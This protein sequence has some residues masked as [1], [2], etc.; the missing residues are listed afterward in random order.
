MRL[1]AFQ[2]VS[3]LK[4]FME[5]GP[6]KLGLILVAINTQLLGRFLCEVRVGA[7]MRIMTGRT[8]SL[9]KRLMSRSGLFRR[10]QLLVLVALT[11]DRF[12]LVIQ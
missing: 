4:G 8:V 2:A 11:T 5:F 10:E 12:L 1:V 9:L 6:F 7:P 3:V